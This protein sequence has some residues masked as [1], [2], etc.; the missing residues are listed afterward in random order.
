[1]VFAEGVD[2]AKEC[3]P[4]LVA[5]DRGDRSGLRLGFRQ[6]DDLPLLCPPVVPQVAD[7]VLDDAAQPAAEGTIV[8]VIEGREISVSGQVS[9]LEDITAFDDGPQPRPQ[10][11]SNKHEGAVGVD[12]KQ[13]VIRLPIAA[14]GLLP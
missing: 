5:L 8:R 2:T 14:S 7:A 4:S 9:I 1:M 11:G 3:L 13:A 6:G 10:T 12:G